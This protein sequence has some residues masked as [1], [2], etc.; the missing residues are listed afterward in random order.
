MT[1]TPLS[2]ADIAAKAADTGTCNNNTDSKLGN[3]KLGR[4]RDKSNRR[5][6]CSNNV[7]VNKRIS[8]LLQMFKQYHGKGNN[9]EAVGGVCSTDGKS[10]RLGKIPMSVHGTNLTNEEIMIMTSKFRSNDQPISYANFGGDRS[11]KHVKWNSKGR[12][13]DVALHQK[14][15]NEGDGI[16]GKFILCANCGGTGHVYRI[17][18]HP[19]TSFG[20]ICY[21]WSYDAHNRA[22]LPQYLMVRRKDSLCYVE[23]IRGKY[24]LHNKEYI[25]KLFQNMTP[26]EREHIRTDDFDALW[27]AFWQADCNKNYMKEYHNAKDKFMRLRVG[28]LTWNPWQ[29]FPHLGMGRDHRHETADRSDS[30]DSM[31][32]Y[33]QR[34][35]SS[36]DSDSEDHQDRVCPICENGNI[37]VGFGMEFLLNSTTAMYEEAEWGFPKGRRNINESDVDCAFREFTEETGF[38]THQIELMTDMEP[39][40][41]I[42]TGCNNIRYKH[43]YFIAQ[44]QALA[45]GSEVR[46]EDMAE[47][48]NCE[49]FTVTD[50]VQAREISSVAWFSFDEAYRRIRAHNVE[51]RELFEKVNDFIMT[52][53]PFQDD[54]ESERGDEKNSR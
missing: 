17:C 21:R 41:E 15:Q 37:D 40:E 24:S 29:A 54:C 31:V 42:F 19:I 27:Y 30:S 5:V 20:V 51:R 10:V 14:I 44:Q 46:Q 38:S 6:G 35:G 34:D 1:V 22:Y 48:S 32:S 13:V 43:V 36:E 28:G 16:P 39:S 11:N 52:K 26:D 25:V 49:S 3:N 8:M 9:A 2:Y 50:K 12:C 53:C 4:D 45:T 47:F 33:G 7:H 23:F 18:H